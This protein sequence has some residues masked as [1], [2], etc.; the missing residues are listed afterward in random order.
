MSYRHLRA[1]RQLELAGK[2][3]GKQ[4]SEDGITAQETCKLKS[5]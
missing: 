4:S 3:Q 5:N 2:G 1:G